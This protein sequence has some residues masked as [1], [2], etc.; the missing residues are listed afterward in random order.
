[1]E[2]GQ[3]VRV[4][5]PPLLG[6][7]L[8]VAREPLVELLVRV[9]HGGHDE[10]EEGP[11][12]GGEMGEG[13]TTCNGHSNPIVILFFHGPPVSFI[14]RLTLHKITKCACTRGKRTRKQENKNKSERGDEGGGNRQTEKKNGRGTVEAKIKTYAL[15][16]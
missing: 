3:L 12:L 16:V 15:D 1:M 5:S 6:V 4:Q 14:R 2:P 8:N 13:E 7:A 9:E 11:Q 10:M